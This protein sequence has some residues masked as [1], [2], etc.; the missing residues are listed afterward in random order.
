MK[1]DHLDA[2]QTRLA[3]ER[4]RYSEATGK[5]KEYRAFM[6]SQVEKEIEGEKAFLGF[7]VGDIDEDEL[8][9]DLGI[10]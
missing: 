10:D 2:L 6:V 9:I 8:M 5:D 3:N 1:F 7:H 4:V